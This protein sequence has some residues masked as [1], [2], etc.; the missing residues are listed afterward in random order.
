MKALGR[1]RRDRG[2]CWPPDAHRAR[3]RAPDPV[4]LGR[5]CERASPGEYATRMVRCSR[6]RASSQHPRR[7]LGSATFGQQSLSPR[8]PP[9]WLPSEVG[10]E[11]ARCRLD[12]HHPGHADVARSPGRA[13]SEV[14]KRPRPSH[15][16]CPVFLARHRSARAWADGSHRRVKAPSVWMA[17][18]RPAGSEQLMT[19]RRRSTPRQPFPPETNPSQC[20][21]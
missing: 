12:P 8:G 3:P 2:L 10:G 4:Q 14:A 6:K 15:R 19:A 16:A 1:R 9:A 18:L 5:S 11:S 7:V 21:S 13:V 17:R 20:G